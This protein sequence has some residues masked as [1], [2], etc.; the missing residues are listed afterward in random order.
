MDTRIFKINLEEWEQMDADSKSKI[1]RHRTRRNLWLRLYRKQ[2]WADNALKTENII[3]TI[4]QQGLLPVR[5]PGFYATTGKHFGIIQVKNP[6]IKSY[7]SICQDYPERIGEMAWR[8][9]LIVKNLHAHPMDGHLF[10]DYRDFFRHEV[11]CAHLISQK[12]D[13]YLKL[14]DSLPEASCYI[15]GH[16]FS[17]SFYAD[18]T[19]DLID[20]LGHF[21]RG[22]PDFDNAMLYLMTF[23]LP[24]FWYNIHV[25]IPRSITRQFYNV[26][27]EEY[28]GKFAS[29]DEH[30]CMFEKFVVLYG[31]VMKR[32]SGIYP[33]GYRRLCRKWLYP[34]NRHNSLLRLL[35]LHS[36]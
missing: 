10:G 5:Q 33:A 28:Y 7:G 11:Q 30:I 35:G 36:V 18:T 24:Y 32:E 13:R 6:G 20:N 17:D 8:M 29:M 31:L 19:D 27:M 25:R 1:Y 21:S 26:Y 3:R 22:V 15:H 14:I 34:Q 12:K 9:S 16:L 4:Q 23:H 2:A